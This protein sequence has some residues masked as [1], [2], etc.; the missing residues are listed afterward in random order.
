M[1]VAAGHLSR[2]ETGKRPPTE[3]V[4]TKCDEVFPER[5]GWFSEFYVDSRS[6]VPPGFRPWGEYEDAATTLRSW[7]PGILTGLIQTP[8]YARAVLS[9]APGATNEQVT[10]RLASRMER[11]RRVFQRSNPPA[12]W[13]VIDEIALYRNMGSPEV[14]AA[15]MARLL[16]IA[17]MP[18]VTLTVMPTVVHAG[19]ESGFVIADNTAVY[20]EHVAGGYVFT[21]GEITTSTV[22]RFDSLRAE[23]YRASEST[24]LI[25]RVTEIWTTGARQAIAVPTAANAL[26]SPRPRRASQSVTQPTATGERLTFPPAHGQPS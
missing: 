22:A 11:Q 3:N 26:R 9:A 14:M 1:G 7:Y 17:A 5:R 18:G 23:S 6:W 25:R 16:D 20:A 19:N 2:I 13:F 21:E 4:A 8:D 10:A 24:A 15:Q 12:T